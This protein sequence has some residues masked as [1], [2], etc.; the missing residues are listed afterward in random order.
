MAKRETK[1]RKIYHT[2]GAEYRRDTLEIAEIKP[3]RKLGQSSIDILTTTNLQRVHEVAHEAARDNGRHGGD[4][5][6]RNAH[7][8]MVALRE[9]PTGV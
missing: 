4:Q 1:N 3:R 2:R 6:P 5:A 8:A 7:Q 9:L